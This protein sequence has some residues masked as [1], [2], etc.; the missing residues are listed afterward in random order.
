MRS[1][2]R[3]GEVGRYETRPR[4]GRLT[5]I[6]VSARLVRRVCGLAEVPG[7]YHGEGGRAAFWAWL[8]SDDSG[9]VSLVLVA[10]CTRLT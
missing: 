6:G 1:P 5:P 2:E 10:A 8:Y 9:C 7:F 3:G 4:G